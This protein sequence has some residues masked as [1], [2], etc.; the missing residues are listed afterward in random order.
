MLNAAVHPSFVR[1][2]K[3][4]PNEARISRTR[5]SGAFTRRPHVGVLASCP[6][7]CHPSETQ[8]V[9]CPCAH[10]RAC[11]CAGSLT[12]IGTVVV[13]VRALRRG[14]GLAVVVWTASKS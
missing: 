12:Q 4:S 14:D 3:S 6:I 1:K 5:F 2:T 11:Q 8:V 10:A 9:G 13:R 7:S